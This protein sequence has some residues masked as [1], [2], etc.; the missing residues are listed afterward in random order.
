MF[1]NI[2]NGSLHRCAVTLEKLTNRDDRVGLHPAWEIDWN[3]PTAW[4]FLFECLDDIGI[5][6]KRFRDPPDVFSL[7]DA[8]SVAVP[9]AVDVGLPGA[10]QSCMETRRGFGEG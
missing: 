4:K 2:K 5:L 10:A 9:D 6:V 1:T 8:G 3:S 7:K